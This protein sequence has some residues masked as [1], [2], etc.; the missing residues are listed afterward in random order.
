M[1]THVYTEMFR[2]MLMWALLVI[3]KHWAQHKCSSTVGRNR[4]TFCDVHVTECCS[5]EGMF[6]CGAGTQTDG[7]QVPSER[8]QTRVVYVLGWQF[9]TF[10]QK[11]N[12]LDKTLYWLSGAVGVRRAF[13]QKK[14]TRICSGDSGYLTIPL[15]KL[16]ELYSEMWVSLYENYALIINWQK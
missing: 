2:Q 14:I 4:Q 10:S 9:K 5:A 7:P 1:K 12:Y 3:T 11:Q 8:L 13:Y 16:L 6:Q 15:T